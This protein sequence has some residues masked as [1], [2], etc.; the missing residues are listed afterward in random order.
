MA[1]MFQGILLQTEVRGHLLCS[2]RK[3]GKYVSSSN[4]DLKQIS[5]SVKYGHF[6]IWNVKRA[7]YL[8]PAIYDKIL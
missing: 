4:V 2:G 8:I 5:Y 3:F 6:H 7:S 1:N